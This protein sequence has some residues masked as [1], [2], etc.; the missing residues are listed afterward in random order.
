MTEPVG[1][2][3]PAEQRV[4]A[5]LYTSAGLAAMVLVVWH[6]LD[7]EGPQEWFASVRDRVRTWRRERREL[8]E[9]YLEIVALPETEPER[10]A[11]P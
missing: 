1:A 9:Q 3:P 4:L 10:C 8:A 2:S 11:E 6:Q 7:P 5:A